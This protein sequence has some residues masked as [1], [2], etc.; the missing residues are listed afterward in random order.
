MVFCCFINSQLREYARTQRRQLAWLSFLFSCGAGKGF[1]SR[2]CWENTAFCKGVQ[3][4]CFLG[5]TLPVS[6]FDPFLAALEARM[7]LQFS[8]VSKIRMWPNLACPAG[9]AKCSQKHFVEVKLREQFFSLAASGC[10]MWDAYMMSG[11]G[12]EIYT[13][14]LALSSVNSHFQYVK[15][16]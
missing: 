11:F 12:T 6:F 15:V 7:A 3:K 16:M 10:R 5:E 8:S 1:C 14:T 2:R 13:A 4:N 9:F